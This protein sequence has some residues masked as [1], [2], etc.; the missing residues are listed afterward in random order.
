MGVRQLVIV[1]VASFA[2]LVLQVVGSVFSSGT[3]RVPIVPFTAIFI[4][5]MAMW[6][7]VW[8]AL[9]GFFGAA[10]YVLPV[11]DVL[12]A[13]GT[14]PDNFLGPAIVGSLARAFK[15]DPSLPT[16]RDYLM[17]GLGVAIG[18]AVQS[19]LGS[20]FFFVL[21]MRTGQELPGQMVAFWARLMIASLVFAPI[22]LR[23]LT[24]LVRRMG[25]YHP[26]FLSAQTVH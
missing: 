18:T 26:S 10:L 17:Y 8:G 22:L 1:V 6:F 24:P 7:G 4:I 12:V 21:G 11:G 2:Y 5:P 19:V 20:L 3:D 23:L 25:V 9:G 13:F 16:S 15:V 14:A